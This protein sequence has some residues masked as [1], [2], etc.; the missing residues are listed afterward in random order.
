[1]TTVS[2]HTEYPHQPQC[3]PAALRSNTGL[4]RVLLVTRK[5]RSPVWQGLF[6]CPRGVAVQ[7]GSRSTHSKAYVQQGVLEGLSQGQ[8]MV[9]HYSNITLP[10][11]RLSPWAPRNRAFSSGMALSPCG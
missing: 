10:E 7:V 5:P 2:T 1:M 8:G 9:V 3:A 4:T 11:H 6:W